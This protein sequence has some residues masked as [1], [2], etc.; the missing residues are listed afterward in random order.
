[1]ENILFNAES[2]KKFLDR[3]IWRYITSKRLR[4]IIDDDGIYFATPK[5]QNGN[6]SLDSKY[7]FLQLGLNSFMLNYFLKNDTEFIEY[8]SELKQ[9]PVI[10][11]SQ[12]KEQQNEHFVYY[13]KII[14][15]LRER[16]GISCWYMG[17]E[18]NFNLW[19]SYKDKKGSFVIQSTLRNVLES[20]PK[21][22][23]FVVGK[24]DYSKGSPEKDMFQTLLKCFFRK[25]KYY[26]NEREIR[27]ITSLSD[28]IKLKELI[29][30][31]NFLANQNL[32][33]CICNSKKDKDGGKLIEIE[34]LKLIINSIRSSPLVESKLAKK[35]TEKLKK[36]GIH[37]D[38]SQ[39]V[40][41]VDDIEAYCKNIDD[42]ADKYI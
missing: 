20:L 26:T 2:D 4:S 35:Y 9:I 10:P 3:K 38:K 15:A 31:P 23:L 16:I 1:M 42:F 34:N 13:S 39:M 14:D 27:I 28:D 25:R 5:Q 41:D 8:E 40:K 36:N 29:V 6:D 24:I 18:E 37:I 19:N 11:G 22:R 30:K 32:Y 33:N 7:S 17:N 21:D 12:V